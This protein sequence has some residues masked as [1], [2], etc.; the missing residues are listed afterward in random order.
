M[1]YAVQALWVSVE[2]VDMVLQAGA[3]FLGLNQ[4]IVQQAQ[5]VVESVTALWQFLQHMPG[6]TQQGV[7]AAF[8]VV[9][10]VCDLLAAGHYCF[11]VGQ[12]AIT[13]IRPKLMPTSILAITKPPKTGWM[14]VNWESTTAASCAGSLA[15]RVNPGLLLTERQAP[16]RTCASW[17]TY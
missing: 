6:T 15:A 11:C 7:N 3:G 2:M 13:V 10:Q 5:C 9:T 14:N 17:V 16:C 8:V 12:L 1:L 4:G